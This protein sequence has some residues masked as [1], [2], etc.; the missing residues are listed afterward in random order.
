MDMDEPIW[1]PTVFTENRD[2]LL[3]QIARSFLRR[4]VAAHWMSEAH[5]TVDGTLIEAWASQKSFQWKD[6]DPEGTEATSTWREPGPTVAG[7]APYRPRSPSGGAAATVR[8]VAGKVASRFRC[9]AMASS[10]RPHRARIMASRP[11]VPG[12]QAEY[13]LAMPAACRRSGRA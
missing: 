13:A 2:R 3:N 10:R 8:L 1:A 6:G 9:N 11:N 4:V 12:V 5:F 7:P